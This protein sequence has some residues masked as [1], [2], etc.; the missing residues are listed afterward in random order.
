MEKWRI[1]TWG[2]SLNAVCTLKGGALTASSPATHDISKYTKAKV[3]QPVQ[4]QNCLF[5]FLQ[6]GERG[7]RLI[8]SVTF[9]V[10]APSSFILKATGIWSETILLL[11]LSA[12]YI[13]FPTW[14][15]KRDPRTGRRSAQNNWISGRFI[16]WILPSDYCCHESEASAS[17]R[18]MHFSENTLFSFYNANN[19]RV[20]CKFHSGLSRALRTS[21]MRKLQVTGMDRN[22]TE[23]IFTMQLSVVTSQNGRCMCK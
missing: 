9:E 11:S 6:L 10:D 18:N 17:F 21:Q 15:V 23:R 5:V 13:T 4:K 16:A 22:S 1:S 7:M 14:A 8:V 2:S 3:L 12:M 19:E 20:W